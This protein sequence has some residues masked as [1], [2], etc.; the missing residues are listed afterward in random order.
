MT[1]TLS[2]DCDL[3]IFNQ[4]TDLW[5]DS[6][7]DFVW[8]T[9]VAEV[10]DVWPHHETHTIRSLIVSLSGRTDV[11]G[12]LYELHELENYV[13]TPSLLGLTA[14]LPTVKESTDE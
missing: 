13:P 7:W 14:V 3:P 11:T 9:D 4:V 6:P 1:K 8:D 10:T 2:P 12:Y 5:T